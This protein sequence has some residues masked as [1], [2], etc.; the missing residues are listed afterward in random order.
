M[1]HVDYSHDWEKSPRFMFKSKTGRKSLK[2]RKRHERLDCDLTQL[3]NDHYFE[4]TRCKAKS[5]YTTETEAW[6]MAYKAS[7]LIGP[8]RVYKCPMC[9]K[10][11][12]TTEVEQAV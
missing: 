12:L 7:H 2:Q 4:L 5:S 9:G 8:C 11:H 3:S 6:V 1:C 10:Y